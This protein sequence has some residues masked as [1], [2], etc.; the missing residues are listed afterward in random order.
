MKAKP[1]YRKRLK[2]VI[3]LLNKLAEPELAE[4]GEQL[5]KP[6]AERAAN[7]SKGSKPK[8]RPR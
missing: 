1:Q 6:A 3:D 4:P 2:G 8:R 7:E 5:A